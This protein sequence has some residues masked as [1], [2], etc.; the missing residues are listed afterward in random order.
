MSGTGYKSPLPDLGWN[1]ERSSRIAN[2]AL[3][4]AR[5]PDGWHYGEGRG[6]TEAAVAS[7]LKSLSV[8]DG[9]GVDE[10][11]IEV[12][13]DIEG[14]ILVSGYPARGSLEIFC[15]PDGRIDITR[16][17]E[18]ETEYELD[19]VSWD[20]LKDCVKVQWQK[21]GKS[22]GFSIP[23]TSAEKNSDSRAWHSKTPQMTVGFPLSIQSVREIKAGRNARI[24]STITSPE[25]RESRP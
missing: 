8:L 14:G 10:R 25:F 15:R 20:R 7:A 1:S 2:R 17:T 22:Y 12:F 5:L 19:D 9:H 11:D 3:S 24:Y 18:G 6:A 23:G 13:P 4:F 21:S 16:E